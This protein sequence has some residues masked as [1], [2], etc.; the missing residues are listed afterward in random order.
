MMS[1]FCSLSIQPSQL[2]FDKLLMFASPG[3]LAGGAPR[4]NNWLLPQ[5]NS[6]DGLALTIMIS[7]MKGMYAGCAW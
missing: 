1:L 7:I 2:G 6:G 4:G 3:V 5:M